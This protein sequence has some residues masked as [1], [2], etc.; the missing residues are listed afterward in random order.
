[1]V[2]PQQREISWQRCIPFKR[3]RQVDDRC[4]TI[5]RTF[6]F[7]GAVRLLL[8]ALRALNITPTQQPAPPPVMRRR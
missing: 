5:V 1:M 3:N 6:K 7:V 8:Q 2:P 4:Q